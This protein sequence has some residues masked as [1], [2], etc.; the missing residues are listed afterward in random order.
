[1]ALQKVWPLMHVLVHVPPEHT[2]PCPHTL[3]HEPQLL[4]S[5]FVFAQYGA[6]PSG[7]QNTSVPPSPPP[8]ELPHVPFEHT[9]PWPHL[10]PHEPQLLLSVCVWAQ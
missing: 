10:L 8:H 5:D 6:P 2:R 1:L 3:P 7:W 9:W 4:L